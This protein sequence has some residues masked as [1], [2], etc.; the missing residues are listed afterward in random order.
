MKPAGR[1]WLALP[2]LL[3][4]ACFGSRSGL[5]ANTD[6]GNAGEA[7]AARAAASPRVATRD[8]RLHVLFLGGQSNVI[9]Q[10][11]TAPP[12]IPP[13][14]EIPMLARCLGPS[15]FDFDSGPEPT[16]LGA[17][18]GFHSLEIAA[19][20]ELKRAG[21]PIAVVKLAVGNSWL[22]EW[23]PAAPT[24]YW[25]A[26]VDMHDRAEHA[27]GRDLAWHFV[28]LQSES[29]VQQANRTAVYADNLRGFVEEIRE[30]F[31]PIDFWQCKLQPSQS[32]ANGTLIRAAQ[33][34]V[35]ASDPRNHL[36]DFDDLNGALHYTSPQLDEMG[37][38]VA[39]ALRAAEP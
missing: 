21:W 7:P 23:R 38:R 39:V 8:T 4:V 32:N 30:E 18:H 37:R 14:P 2:A 25:R 13:D 15:G 6:Q 28:W 16:P 12:A 35:M 10:Y 34:E 5:G 11:G 19:A 17:V 3:P 20:T 31:G 24:G 27:W 1:Y 26:L 36:L 9:A 33:V 29:D 22:G